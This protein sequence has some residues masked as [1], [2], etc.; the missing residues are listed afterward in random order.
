MINI[1]RVTTIILRYAYN[2]KHSFDRMSDMFYWPAMDLLIWGLTGLYFINRSS[3][4]SSLLPVII[5]GLVFWIVVWRTQ[6]EITTNMLSEIWD[7]NIVNIFASPLKLSEW[8]IAFMIFGV[9]KMTISLMFSGILAYLLYK[10]NIFSY[11]LYL[12]PLT[13]NLVL[14]GWAAGFIVSGFLIRFGNTI[15]TLAWAGVYLIAPFSGIYYSITILPVWAQKVAVF[16][17]TSYIFEGFREIIFTGRLSENKIIFALV[18][19]LIYLVL[20]ICFFTLM[21]HKSRK[22]GL[23]RLIL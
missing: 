4:F 1:S 11:G 2:M 21:F 13:A 16:V 6:Y 20:S 19:N 23:G 5:T 12:V 3:E 15:Q 10:V 7:K 22:L 9:I 14:T 17:P 18:L 8:I